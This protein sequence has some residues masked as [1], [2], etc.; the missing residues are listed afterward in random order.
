MTGCFYVEE[1]PIMAGKYLIR[2]NH[3]KLRLEHT[4][5]SFNI[6]TA[7]CLG[8][9]YANYLR[10]CRDRYGATIIGKGHKYPVAYFNKVPA[11]ELVKTLNQR[12]KEI[13]KGA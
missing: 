7:R 2:P 5:G 1:S 8:L 12:A 10:L 4:N 11:E 6:I 9:T 13:L 3:D